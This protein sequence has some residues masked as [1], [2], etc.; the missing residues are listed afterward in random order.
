MG[1]F[2]Q[3]SLFSGDRP[4]FKIDK[5]IRIIQL[6]AGYGSQSLSLKY[7]GVPFEHWTI[8]EWAVKSIQAFKDMHF[9]DDNTDYSKDM[10]VEEIREYL[11]GRISSDYSNP[12]PDKTIDRMKEDELRKIIN[13]MRATHNCGSIVKM[14]ADDLG[15][16]D[17]DKYCY[18][19]TYS[20]PCQDLSKSGKQNG[21][22]K[23]S[24]TRSGTL[25]EVERLLR[26][27]HE[28]GKLLPQV[29]LMENVP[30][31]VGNKFFK[32]FILWTE[33][34]QSIGYTS[35]YFI[36]NAKYH[37]IPQNRE[38]C[39]MVSVLGDYE[40]GQPATS[41]SRYAL[42]DFLE[43]GVDEKY[44]LTEDQVREFLSSQNVNVE[45]ERERERDK[46]SRPRRWKRQP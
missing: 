1:G 24:G 19:M 2:E 37:E 7:L 3:L 23:G 11:K 12:I 38:R 16:V 9:P 46:P 25:W 21:M 40:I 29:L 17:A 15:I 30:D 45:R 36:D 32:D 5:V 35:K 18:I 26:E 6:F 20:F 10:T 28:N 44:Y 22:T 8:S 13:N 42:I 41:E 34:L 14:S 43:V 33:F 4:R 39:F 27:I 31:V